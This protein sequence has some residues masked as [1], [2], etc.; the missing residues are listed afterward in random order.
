MSEDRPLISIVVVTYNSAKY[1]IE[2]LDSLLTQTYQGPMELL[3]SDDGSVDETICLCKNWVKRNAGFFVHIEIL[4]TPHNL[5][6]CGN[7]NYA[8][9][10]LRGQWVKYIAGDDRLMPDCIRSFIETAMTTGDKFLISGVNCIDKA[11]KSLGTRY[12]MKD[13]LDVN[14]PDAQ[15]ENLATYGGHGI[16]EGPS[17]FINTA[18]LRSLGGMDMVYPM[19]EDFPIAFKCA[20]YGYHIGVIKRPLVEY[21][22]YQESISQSKDYFHTMYQRAVYDARKMIARKHHRYIE[23]WHHHVMKI[24]SG[25]P[26]KGRLSRLT[27][28]LLKCT[29]VYM[30]LN[31]LYKRL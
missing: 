11:G 21:R 20:F 31:L 9:M 28:G 5:G 26:S 6:I 1:V 18:L 2:T 3:I 15:A 23:M 27:A 14:D 19:L 7:Y 29:D 25:L 4:R 22:I 24:L 10:S 8:L 16:I 13:Y 12:L 30:V 17:L